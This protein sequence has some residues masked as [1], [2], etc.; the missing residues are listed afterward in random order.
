MESV[1]IETGIAP[2]IRNMRVEIRLGNPTQ[3]Y[4]QRAFICKEPELGKTPEQSK[5]ASDLF[6]RVFRGP[7][8]PDSKP[9]NVSGFVNVIEFP[10][11]IFGTATDISQRELTMSIN[12]AGKMRVEEQEKRKD[13][14]VKNIPVGIDSDVVAD[15]LAF[16]IGQRKAL[17]NSGFNAEDLNSLIGQMCKQAA[18]ARAVTLAE[19]IG[20]GERVSTD[21]V[22]KAFKDM[23]GV[24]LET[25]WSAIKGFGE[26]I[27]QT[28]RVDVK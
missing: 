20:R 8:K 18:V 15:Q 17:I 26:L 1:G 5:P 21:E 25:A 10:K 16:L 27:S 6:I 14:S 3:G 7:E 9:Q 28:Y 12:R 23:E 2:Q 13:G 4:D 22:E 19:R 11:T 24:S